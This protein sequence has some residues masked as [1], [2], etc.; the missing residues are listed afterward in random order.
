MTKTMKK[1]LCRVGFDRSLP[2]N[3]INRITSIVWATNKSRSTRFSG[4]IGPLRQ[5]RSVLDRGKR[6]PFVKEASKAKGAGTADF[7]GA[8]STEVFF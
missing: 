4:P 2:T 7:H 6:S 5:A 3:L 8:D 1:T